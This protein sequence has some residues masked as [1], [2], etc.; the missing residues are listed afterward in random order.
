M[1][2]GTRRESAFLPGVIDGIAFQTNILALN[3]AMEA[4]RVGEHVQGGCAASEHVSC[5]AR[6]G[7]QVAM[8]ALTM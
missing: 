1:P 3:A 8:P 7:A 2:S 4:A 5:F 6:Q